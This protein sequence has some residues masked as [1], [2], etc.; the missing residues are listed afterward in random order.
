MHSTSTVP[1]SGAATPPHGTATATA[2]CPCPRRSCTAPI[3][4]GTAR[5]QRAELVPACSAAALPESPVLRA[6]LAPRG[7]RRFHSRG[8][9][10]LSNTG[11][12]AAARGRAGRRGAERA[13]SPMQRAEHTLR[14]TVTAPR[15]SAA[16]G[17]WGRTELKVPTAASCSTRRDG[18]GTR[19][20]AWGRSAGSS[21]S[22]KPVTVPPS[23][24]HTAHRC[25]SRQSGGHRSAQ[26]LRVVAG[27]ATFGTD[28]PSSGPVQKGW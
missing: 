5:Q 6:L 28:I 20:C 9:R 24:Q 7:E 26:S 21:P 12:R 2:T 10:R 1:W 27:F 15:Q 25:V 11:G 14:D 4:A 19:C 8:W 22:H 13:L 16:E 23:Q 17:H 18:T 3:A